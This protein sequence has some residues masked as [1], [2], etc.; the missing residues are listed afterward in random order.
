[1]SRETKEF[2]VRREK[3]ELRRK[4]FLSFRKQFSMS[5]S[6][7]AGLAIILFFTF[8]AI[9]ANYISPFRRFD[10]VGPS[11]Q[12]PSLTFI[13][14]TDSAGRDVLSERI[15]GSR[16]SLTVGITASVASI[17]I[18]TILGVVSG[19]YG[20]T[21]DTIIMRIVDI[22]LVIPGLPLMIVIAVAIGGQ[23]G[24]VAIII[25]IAILGRAGTA[26]LVRSQVL[27]IREMPYVEAARAAG[28]SAGYIIRRHVLPNVMPL[29]FAQAVLSVGGAIM[30]EAGIAFLGFT[31]GNYISR[32]KMMNAF[33]SQPGLLDK[34]RLILTPGGAIATITF[35]FMMLGYAFDEILNPR[36]RRR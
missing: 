31:S 16:V 20:G 14:G 22:F 33:L 10:F 5:R 11:L 30:S 32:G 8:V 23:L 35:A 4:R 2:S 24:F 25:V 21:V 12:K 17:L 36:L 28:G 34:R 29:V 13:F 9:F 7:M 15:Q 18:G 26:R 27:A 1:M 6:G 3:L 19:Y